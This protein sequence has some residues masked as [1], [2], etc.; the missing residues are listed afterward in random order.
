[1]LLYQVPK[2][3]KV[4]RHGRSQ[5]LQAARARPA[6]PVHDRELLRVVGELSRAAGIATPMVMV[7]DEPMAN[8]FAASTRNGAVVCVTHQA[9]ALLTD[10]ELRGVLAH[11]IGHVV[12]RDTRYSCVMAAIYASLEAGCLVVGYVI[13]A[14]MA[15]GEKRKRDKQAALAFGFALGWL[16]CRIGNVA[17]MLGNR[18]RELSADRIG[19]QISGDPLALASALRR[20]EAA[21]KRVPI[22]RARELALVSPLCVV[23]ALS[24]RG[25][26]GLLSSHPTTNRRVRRLHRATTPEQ[27]AAYE[28]EL[29]QARWMVERQAAVDRYRFAA[30]LEPQVTTEPLGRPTKRERVWGVE[31]S[32]ALVEQRQQRGRRHFVSTGHGRILVTDRRIIYLGAKKTEWRYDKL[33]DF[34]LDQ[35]ESGRR[36][37]SSRSRIARSSRDSSPTSRRRCS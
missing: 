33:S 34:R 24:L 22:A 12:N 15:A 29:A 2:Q 35:P 20:L 32:G 18:Q 30:S 37:P 23:P 17:V 1:V 14:I 21:D 13:G 10:R 5:H 28:L 6:D 4:W 19:A 7:S 11:E 26:S 3:L 16:G 27:R 8:A 36:S 9:A 31:Y 25:L